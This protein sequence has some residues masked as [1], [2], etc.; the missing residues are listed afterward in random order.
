LRDRDTRGISMH[1]GMDA[2]KNAADQLSRII[3]AAMRGEVTEEQR[4]RQTAARC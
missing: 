4:K 3:E 2:S 1:M